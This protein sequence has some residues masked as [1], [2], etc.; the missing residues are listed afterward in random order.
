MLTTI[1]NKQIQKKPVL[2]VQFMFRSDIT[3][4]TAHY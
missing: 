2:Y 1:N 4:I 3:Q